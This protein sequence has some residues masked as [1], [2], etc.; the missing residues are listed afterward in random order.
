MEQSST[1][2]AGEPP[3]Q[4]PGRGPALKALQAIKFKRPESVIDRYPPEEIMA[5]IVYA[6]ANAKTPAGVA[7]YV[8]AVL[9]KRYA[10]PKWAYEK[11]RKGEGA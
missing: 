8:N 3:P 7:G 4:A 10:I 1:A 5:A 9:A 6:K 11:A 2:A